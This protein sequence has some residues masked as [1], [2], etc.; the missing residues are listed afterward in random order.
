MSFLLTATPAGSEYRQSGC[1]VARLA[2]PLHA[3]PTQHDADGEAGRHQ[4]DHEGV[5]YQQVYQ[6]LH[7][8]PYVLQ[9]L[10]ESW[11]FTEPWPVIGAVWV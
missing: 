5:G 7:G 3:R 8:I 9:Q 2:F 1:L 11:L 6:V 4:H 10:I